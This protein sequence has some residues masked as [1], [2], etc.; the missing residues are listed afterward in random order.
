MIMWASFQAMAPLADA[1]RMGIQEQLSLF[2][3][4]CQ[5]GTESRSAV[6]YWPAA[7]VLTSGSALH[8]PL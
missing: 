6:Q 2:L 5:G 1:E 7:A 4:R 8:F 3:N